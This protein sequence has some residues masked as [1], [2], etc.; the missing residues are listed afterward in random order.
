MGTRKYVALLQLICFISSFFVFGISCSIRNL[1]FYLSASNHGCPQMQYLINDPELAPLYF[2]LSACCYPWHAIEHSRN[3]PQSLGSQLEAGTRQPYFFSLCCRRCRSFAQHGFPRG[4]MKI[5][6][7]V[8]P[9]QAMLCRYSEMRRHN[10]HSAF[11]HFICQTG[12]P[13]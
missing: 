8:P 2:L 12:L 4:S 9:S 1:F 6:A 10:F 11:E 7:S 3:D 5:P 13:L